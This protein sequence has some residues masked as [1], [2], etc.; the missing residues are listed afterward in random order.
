MFKLGNKKC[1]KAKK[2]CNS[3]NAKFNRSNES[4]MN[5]KRAL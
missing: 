3:I 1:I 4:S 5:I 2:K